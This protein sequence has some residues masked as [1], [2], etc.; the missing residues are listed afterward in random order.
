MVHACALDYDFSVLENGDETIV[1]DRGMNFSKGQ[2]ARINLARSIYKDADIYLIDDALTALDPKVQVHIFKHCIKGLLKNK[3]VILVTHNAKH[4]KLADNLVILQDG[5]VTFEGKQ[6]NISEDI[7]DSFE[8]LPLQKND[9]KEK[10][11]QE[12]SNEKE[13]LLI[14]KPEIHRKQVYHE[15]K[16]SGN[17]DYHLYLKYIK[18]SGGFLIG[19]SLVILYIGATFFE[20]T[21]QK[22]MSNW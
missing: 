16:K 11:N 10:E 19:I 17:V 4:I 3:C 8:S 7:L 5:S 14:V 12:E 13:K 1:A 15:N 6:Q 22:T 20:S 21:M 9:E 2:Q 18:Y